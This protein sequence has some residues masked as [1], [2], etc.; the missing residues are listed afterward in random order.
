MATDYSTLKTDVQNWLENDATEFTSQLDQIIRLAELRIAKES[1]LQRFR[2]TDTAQTTV[3]S[4]DVVS[5]PADLVR[6]RGVQLTASGESLLVKD[7]SFI[8]EY[9]A[10]V[11][12]ESAPKYYS[13]F[14]DG[15]TE[16][17]LV[18]PTPDAAYALT[19]GYTFRPTGLSSGNT[20]TWLSTNAE[21]VLFY[22]VCL[23]SEVFCKAE[24]RD[25]V[26]LQAMYER[27]LGTLRNEEETR[28]RT[29]EYRRGVVNSPSLKPLNP[30][31]KQEG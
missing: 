19:I 22:A 27:G 8:R 21:D 30:I 6:L 16:K 20:T 11:T 9:N 31:H 13:L 10:S 14:Q 17:L 12:T 15:D 24:Q 29:D 28:G 1:N 3:A 26:R 4:S 7:E 18:A 2:K 25:F 23:D 5:V